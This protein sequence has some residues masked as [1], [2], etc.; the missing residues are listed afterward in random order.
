MDDDLKKP[1]GDIAEELYEVLSPKGFRAFV[2]A[3]GGIWV[4]VQ[5]QIKSDGYVKTN[6]SQFFHVLSK[7][8]SIAL[9]SH[10]AG[11]TIP[12]PMCHGFIN[13]EL[14]LVVASL[15]AKGHISCDIARVLNRTQ[16]RIRQIRAVLQRSSA[17]PQNQPPLPHG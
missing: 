3:Y 8:D 13:R 4:Y 15:F 5:G 7:A 1:K 12:V 17:H 16:S 9:T 6:P 11:E 2:E 10:F 14:P